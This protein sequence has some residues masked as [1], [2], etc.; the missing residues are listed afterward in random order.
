MEMD[1]Q[2]DGGLVELALPIRHGIRGLAKADVAE[3][4]DEEQALVEIAGEDGRRGKAGR[5]GSGARY[6][7]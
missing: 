1:E 6:P 7:A 5:S 3:I 2:I 4:V